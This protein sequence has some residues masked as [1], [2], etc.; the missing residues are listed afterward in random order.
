MSIFL[1]PDERRGPFLRYSFQGF[2]KLDT[3][4]LLMKIAAS[5]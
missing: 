4:D 1:V 2:Q 3:T 5:L